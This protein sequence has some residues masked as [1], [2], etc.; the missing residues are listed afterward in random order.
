MLNV[1]WWDNTS[2]HW[3]EALTCELVWHVWS[4][5]PSLAP[6]PSQSTISPPRLSRVLSL[7]LDCQE[8]SV[9]RRISG[10]VSNTKCDGCTH[11]LKVGSQSLN[12]KHLRT[13]W[14]FEFRLR[15]YAMRLTWMNVTGITGTLN[16]KIHV[17]ITNNK[18][19]EICLH[20]H[21]PGTLLLWNKT[22]QAGLS[23]NR[24]RTQTYLRIS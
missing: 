15:V 3:H 14:C 13:R 6:A 23:Y 19:G 20:N 8:Q 2:W 21:L 10:A 24:V 16:Q 7:N 12:E 4:E 11:L 9:E 1:L 17:G 22:K 5:G 18:S